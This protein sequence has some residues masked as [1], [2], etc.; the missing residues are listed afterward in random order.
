[1][2]STI[3]AALTVLLDN[4]QFTPLPPRA[5]QGQEGKP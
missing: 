2:T 4:I 3:R 1:M 5:A